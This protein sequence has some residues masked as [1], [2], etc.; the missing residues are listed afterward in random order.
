MKLKDKSFIRALMA[1]ALSAVL[2]IGA[3]TAFAESNK[4]S[5][6]SEEEQ[7]R[8]MRGENLPGF[9]P[10]ENK[11]TVSEPSEEEQRREMRGEGYVPKGVAVNNGL[12]YAA[13]VYYTTFDSKGKEVE[14]G[15]FVLNSAGVATKDSF[16]ANG[17]TIPA[18]GGITFRPTEAQFGWLV[19]ANYYLCWAYELSGSRTIVCD[20]R[21]ATTS[22]PGT[23]LETYPAFTG[24][25]MAFGYKATS[26]MYIAITLNNTTGSAVT[27]KKFEP[28]IASNYES[29]SKWWNERRP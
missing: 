13:L 7:R 21:N 19:A 25:K 8:E 28:Y 2:S 12:P 3:L 15:E 29:A 4:P 5:E 6:P 9:V 20:V 10:V 16:P 27:A 11:Q 24:S 14:S 22:M 1:V 23:V 17:V 26:T 18:N